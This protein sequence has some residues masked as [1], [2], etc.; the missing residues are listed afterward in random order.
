MHKYTFLFLSLLFLFFTLFLSVSWNVTMFFRFW[1]SFGRSLERARPSVMKEGLIKVYWQKEHNRHK[2]EVYETWNKARHLLHRR[3]NQV[4]LSYTIINF[5]C[6]A[7]RNVLCFEAKT[8]KI[9]CTNAGPWFQIY[10]ATLSYKLMIA[11]IFSIRYELIRKYCA[12][13]SK[14][15]DGDFVFLFFTDAIILLYI[16]LHASYSDSI[17]DA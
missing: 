10:L 9:C 1:I 12:S 4:I 14:K 2:N 17:M 8:N 13:F 7:L 6:T 16:F 15:E 3:S 5:Y 11:I